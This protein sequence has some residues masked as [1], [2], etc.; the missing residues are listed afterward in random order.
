MLKNGAI[1]LI[2]SFPVLIPMSSMLRDYGKK[3]WGL[4]TKL[5]VHDQMG[6]HMCMYVYTVQLKLACVVSCMKINVKVL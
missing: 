6:V 2:V 1:G 3:P 4:G 5:V